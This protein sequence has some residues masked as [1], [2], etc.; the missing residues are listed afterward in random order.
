MQPTKLFD[1]LKKMQVC[2]KT[3]H[4]LPFVKQE[5]IKIGRKTP[6]YKLKSNWEW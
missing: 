2:S 1:M 6:A 4:I 3:C 5:G